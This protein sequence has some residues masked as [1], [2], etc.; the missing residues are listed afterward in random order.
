MK[1]RKW[2]VKPEKKR[3]KRD[4]RFRKGGRGVGVAVV[5]E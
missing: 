4:C 5:M 2:K 3:S 1:G